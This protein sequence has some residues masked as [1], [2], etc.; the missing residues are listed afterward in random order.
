MDGKETIV[1]TEPKNPRG[2]V[3]PNRTATSRSAAVNMNRPHM[4][5]KLHRQ[6]CIGKPRLSGDAPGGAK[7]AA[8]R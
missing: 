8:H 7:L 6:T 2:T 5:A 4:R 1:A 3:T